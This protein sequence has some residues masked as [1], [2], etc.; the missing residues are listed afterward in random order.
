MFRI[1]PYV[2]SS[3][4][5]IEHVSLR[6]GQF[7]FCKWCIVHYHVTLCVSAVFAVDQC[8]YVHLSVCLSVCLSVTVVYCIQTAE[9]NVKLLSRPCSPITLVFDPKRRYP[10][11]TGNLSAGAQNTRGWKKFCDF[12]L[13]SPFISEMVRDRPMVA[14]ER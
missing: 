1:V 12:R 4:V 2:T 6:I 13:K 8:P 5:R 7:L 3:V 9:N 14:M 11:P 10:I